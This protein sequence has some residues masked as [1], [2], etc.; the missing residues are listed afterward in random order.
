M[1]RAPEYSLLSCRGPL[2]GEPERGTVGIFCTA[3]Q[4]ISMKGVAPEM[5]ERSRH[6]ILGRGQTF[7]RPRESS[8]LD[9]FPNARER[10][11]SESNEKA[12]VV[13]HVVL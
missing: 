4:E 10:A 5:A 2:L 11:G 3:A 1:V 8:I 9:E 12:L 7:V 6:I 13:A